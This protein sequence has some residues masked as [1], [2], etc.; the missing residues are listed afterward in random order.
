MISAERARELS[1]KKQPEAMNSMLSDIE[2]K[3]VNTINR[4]FGQRSIT[5]NIPI[6]LLGNVEKQLKDEGYN[7]RLQGFD[8]LEISW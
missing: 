7:T 3:I 1:A 2:T 5:I 8:T 4:G 6:G